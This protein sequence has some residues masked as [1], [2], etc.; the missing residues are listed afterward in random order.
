MPLAWPDN[1][2]TKAYYQ[3]DKEDSGNSP[4]KAQL[5]YSDHVA[6]VLKFFESFG[7]G[8]L[9]IPKVFKSPPSR[10]LKDP[11]TA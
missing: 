2:S 1:L 10:L 8:K 3:S 9:R 11:G 6:I 5:R 7:V 4:A